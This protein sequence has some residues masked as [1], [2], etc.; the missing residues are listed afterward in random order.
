MKTQTKTILS[1]VLVIVLC[2]ALMT[3]A[4]F[5]LFTSESDTNIAVNAG[6]IEVVAT[7]SIYGAWSAE[8]SNE[9]G[10]YIYP[11]INSVEGVYSFKN[12][13][14]ASMEGDVVNL[15]NITPGDG[16]RIEIE[17]VND[18]SIDIQYRVAV[19]PTKP[20]VLFDAL[21]IGV[22]SD[23]NATKPYATG[24]TP[25]GV[26]EDI[27]SAYVNIEFPL[28]ADLT[29][30]PDVQGESCDIIVTVVAVQGNT[31][32]ENLLVTSGEDL[33]DAINLV[34]D[35]GTI[36]VLD[37]IT[38]TDDAPIE[39]PAGK[40]VTLDAKGNAITAE[41][42]SE[43]GNTI[44]VGKGGNLTLTDS[45][46]GQGKFELNVA[47]SSDNMNSHGDGTYGI[48]VDGGSLNI[49]DINFNIVN[50]QETEHSIYVTNGSVNVNEGAN[51]EFTGDDFAYGFF[52]SEGSE[53]NLNGAS[54]HSKGTVTPIVVGFSQ[55]NSDSVL[56]VNAG[57]NIFFEGA[58]LSGAAIQ[59]YPYGV[60]NI[61]DGATITVEGDLTNNENPEYNDASAICSIG[62]GTVNMDGG[63]IILNATAGWAYAITAVNNYV[64]EKQEYIVNGQS[65]ELS[66]AIRLD[67]HI[68]LSGTAKITALGNVAYIFG[69]QQNGVQS[70]N[71]WYYLEG[72]GYYV[73]GNTSDYG[74][75]IPAEGDDF[76]SLVI[77]NGV[78]ITKD[79]KEVKSTD[80]F[81]A[82]DQE[83]SY[84]L[85]GY[86]VLYTARAIKDNR[87]IA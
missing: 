37:D 25:V 50:E 55:D 14:K 52:I 47:A 23:E 53:M 75:L 56:N 65:V 67:A 27:D 49:E 68:T 21:Q 32:T 51:I 7:A 6:N 81:Y 22:F 15:N 71:K 82:N 2:F 26:G 29:T 3:G 16:V 38:I 59:V 78:S 54:I 4:T 76:Y 33:Q 60:V 18:S 70:I 46:G 41:K 57:T 40:D 31:H 74:T 58:S 62:G 30:N 66:K 20:S 35:G 48:R 72:Y 87:T 34:S 44:Y 9:G 28:T 83:K 73:S 24:W 85:T 64:A 79:G 42:T 17:I 61:H 12:G 77:E 39:V 19:A 80:S 13:G 10:K 11:R 84:K 45:T 5:A 8:W 36:S 43:E 86:L 1:S 63:E 69:V